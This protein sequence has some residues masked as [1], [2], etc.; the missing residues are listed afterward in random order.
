MLVYMQTTRRY[1][2]EDQ[3]FD[4]NLFGENISSI[5]NNTAISLQVSEKLG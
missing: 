4:V 2:P 5:K 3:T 1:V